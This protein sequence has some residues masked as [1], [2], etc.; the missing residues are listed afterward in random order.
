M[1]R[2]LMTMLVGAMVSA[3]AADIIVR[4]AAGGE[5]AGGGTP[6]IYTAGTGGNLI[7][8]LIGG[9]FG[10]PAIGQFDFEADY[11]SGFEVLDTFCIE[12]TQNVEVPLF[13]VDPAG[14]GGWSIIDLTASPGISASEAS[15]LQTLWSNAFALS[16]LNDVN[17]AAFQLLAWE[18][19]LDDGVSAAG[20]ELGQVAANA[21]DPFTSSVLAV[22][23]TWIDNILSAEPIWTTQTP[24]FVLTNPES[25]D[26]LTTVPEPA[27]VMTLLGG[28]LT[29]ALRRRN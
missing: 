18:V 24:L 3:A 11:G 7:A 22:A 6:G 8:T 21:A 27:S 23:S 10:D 17:A 1:Q 16:S 9:P 20:L 14:L 5:S 13:E 2:Y 26:L 28:L 15:F 12:P 25:Q 19:A 4:D 29:L